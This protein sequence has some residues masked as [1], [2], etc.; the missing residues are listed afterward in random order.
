[1]LRNISDLTVAM[2]LKPSTLRVRWIRNS[3]QPTIK[4]IYEYA[5]AVDVDIE[6]FI[7]KMIGFLQQYQ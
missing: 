5:N 1:M 2:N 6:R 4:F 7:E 3:Y